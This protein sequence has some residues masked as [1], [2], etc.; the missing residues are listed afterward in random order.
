MAS[1]Q[2]DGLQLTLPTCQASEVQPLI[3]CPVVWG[4]GARA[5]PFFH[6][7]PLLDVMRYRGLT[8]LE[9][10]GEVAD[11]IQSP[12]YKGR[13]AESSPIL[14]LSS[15]GGGAEFS[16]RIKAIWR[17]HYTECLRAKGQAH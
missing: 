17:D 2:G 6:A 10:G 5:T 1:A 8:L 14:P 12:G 15:T 4:T 7:C 11:N 13:K 16:R 3:K 9:K